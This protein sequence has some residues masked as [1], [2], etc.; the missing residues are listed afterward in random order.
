MSIAK[1]ELFDNLVNVRGLGDRK[2]GRELR[3]TI[4]WLRASQKEVTGKSALVAEVQNLGHIGDL[5][6]QKPHKIPRT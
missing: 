5:V 6:L 2:K 4:T 1:N 3:N